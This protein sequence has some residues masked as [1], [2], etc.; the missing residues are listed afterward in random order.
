[1][2]ATVSRNAEPR[3]AQPEQRTA[4]S[5]DNSASVGPG[6]SRNRPVICSPT[7]TATRIRR[8]GAAGSKTGTDS[9]PPV[10]ADVSTG[11]YVRFRSGDQRN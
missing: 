3:Q 2:L 4:T 5:A 6:H 8:A 1:V 9:F 11:G 10:Q 7:L